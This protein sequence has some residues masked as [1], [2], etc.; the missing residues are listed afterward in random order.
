MRKIIL[1][2]IVILTFSS[3]SALAAMSFTFD[4]AVEDN[5]MNFT[6][7]GDVGGSNNIISAPPGN[8]I[9]WQEE[10]NIGY[11]SDWVL[12]SEP[13]PSTYPNNGNTWGGRMIFPTSFPGY[14]YC[15]QYGER[16]EGG[17]PQTL[18]SWGHDL[19]IEALLPYNNISELIGITDAFSYTEGAY[20]ATNLTPDGSTN[21]TWIRDSVLGNLTLVG[22]N[23][24]VSLDRPNQ[25][26]G[27]GGNG[28]V[29]IPEPATLSLLGLGL[30]GLVFRNKR[31]V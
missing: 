17:Y 16:F 1:F 20:Y 29:I 11:I 18:E 2:C 31:T 5:N 7:Y 10:W 27:P 28:G 26:P 3:S 14:D 12:L 23:Y 6:V 21:A 22:V 25:V 19:R 30:L 24:D 8:G 15:F 9:T 4:G 13:F